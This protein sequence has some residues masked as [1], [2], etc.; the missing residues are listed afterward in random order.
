MTKS[1]NVDIPQTCRDYKILSYHYKQYINRY[2]NT[3]LVYHESL[4]PVSNTIFEKLKL[5]V[6]VYED[7]YLIFVFE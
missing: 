1:E 7:L 5:F 4:N 6:Q 2:P 3:K